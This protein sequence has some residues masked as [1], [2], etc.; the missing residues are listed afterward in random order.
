MTGTVA[1]AG[2]PGA[3]AGGGPS[4]GSGAPTQAPLAPGVATP[5]AI[6]R[7]LPV[8]GGTGGIVR[9][10]VATARRGAILASSTWPPS[11]RS[12]R[13]TS[14]AAPRSDSG[15]PLRPRV[16][17][18]SRPTSR[19]SATTATSVVALPTSTPAIT[20]SGGS[21]GQATAGVDLRRL[22]E[23]RGAAGQ[24]PAGQLARQGRQLPG[25]R[26]A[27][28][29][30]LVDRQDLVIGQ[31][32]QLGRPAQVLGQLR[33]RM[34]RRHLR[35][36]LER[37]GVDP[38]VRQADLA[39]ADRVQG[40]LAD[41]PSRQRAHDRPV[42]HRNPSSDS[43]SAGKP[44]LTQARSSAIR[45]ITVVWYLASIASSL[46]GL[47]AGSGVPPL[48]W[49][50]AFAPSSRYS[51]AVT[52]GATEY[53]SRLA[54]GARSRRWISAVP[55]PCSPIP[56]PDP[57]SRAA[58]SPIRPRSTVSL[59][60]TTRPAHP[61]S[62]SPASSSASTSGTVRPDRQHHTSRPTAGETPIT[63]SRGSWPGTAGPV[64]ASSG[65]AKRACCARRSS[66][67]RAWRM[68]SIS[69]SRWGDGSYP[70]PGPA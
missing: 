26:A 45:A 38:Q 37:F 64:A 21:R 46:Y 49:R 70:V 65:T 63:T 1:V 52:L 56:M 41:R 12:S 47:R 67:P 3:V 39:V 8:G 16:G 14:E 22:R 35:L 4:S 53:S 55:L 42:R 24:A 43:S 30:R 68:A 40:Q 32:G 57:A 25:G 28:P 51:P 50:A 2:P 15:D 58:A 13:R 48:A 66:T 9:V 19:P 69:A 11:R 60:R 6:S 29:E 18:R 5:A 31:P 27:R 44:G 61:S 33:V 7:S 62:S 17:S 54:S 10:V 20:G 59:N 36:P 23:Q 34:R